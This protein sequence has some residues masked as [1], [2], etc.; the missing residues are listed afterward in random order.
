MRFNLRS[1]FIRNLF[2][3]HKMENIKQEFGNFGDILPQTRKCVKEGCFYL[4]YFDEK[5]NKWVDILENQWVD[6]GIYRKRINK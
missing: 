3:I 6:I 2:H 1:S 4:E 5:R